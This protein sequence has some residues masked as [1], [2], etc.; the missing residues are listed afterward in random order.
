[1]MDESEVDYPIIEPDE[2]KLLHL[3]SGVQQKFGLDLLGID[4]IIENRS[5][6][7]AVIDINAFPGYDGVQEFFPA[8]LQLIEEK[9][10][11][12]PAKDSLPPAK[13]AVRLEKASSFCLPTIRQVATQPQDGCC[14][15]T[16]AVISGLENGLSEPPL[17]RAPPTVMKCALF[18]DQLSRWQ[19]GVY[20][21]NSLSDDGS[22]VLPTVTAA[23]ATNGFTTH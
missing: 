13:K 20:G 22:I 6:R 15:P 19:S 23:T 14:A 18:S 10:S 16:T 8:L 17:P 2:D 3:V 21:P 12:I 11:N 4:V 9:F 7:Y 1:M 5:G